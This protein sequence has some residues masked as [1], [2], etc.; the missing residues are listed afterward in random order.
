MN[1]FEQRVYDIIK[2]EGYNVIDVVTLNA[3]DIGLWNNKDVSK[4]IFK[5]EGFKEKLHVFFSVPSTCDGVII[6]QLA[7]VQARQIM[8]TYHEKVSERTNYRSLNDIL[9]NSGMRS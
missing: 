7:D 2:K 5:M 1:N 4:I 9:G 6:D 3:N 8:E